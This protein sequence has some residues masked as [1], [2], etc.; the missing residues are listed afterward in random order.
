MLIQVENCKGGSEEDSITEKEKGEKVTETAQQ[1]QALAVKPDMLSSSPRSHMVEGTD[2]HMC[3]VA[4]VRTY[5]KQ[6]KKS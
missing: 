2:L 1:V 4:H 6:C 3:T 5:T